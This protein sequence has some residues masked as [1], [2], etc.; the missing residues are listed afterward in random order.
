MSAPESYRRG[1]RP[2]PLLAA[3]AV[4]VANLFLHKPLSDMCDALFVRVGRGRYE[5]LSLV[6]IGVISAVAAVPGAL[7][8][9][10][11]LAKT[12]LPLSLFGLALLTMASQRWLLVSNIEL[13]H[14]PQFA[15]IAVL[16]LAAG[17]APK[18]AW[19][20]G[21]V[22]GL[23]DETYQHLVLYA[24]VP[25]TYFDVNDI[26]L[27]AIGAAWGV[28]LFGANRMAG[29]G[30]IVGRSRGYRPIVLSA[31][32][33]IALA[34]AFD[35]P[36]TKLMTRAATGRHYRVLST[37]EG[38]GAIAAVAALVELASIRRGGRR[39]RPPADS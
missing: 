24:G 8:L 1:P 25:N 14:F 5:L 3:A 34:I 22:A 12:W 29:E 37:G 13:V 39:P 17:V 2:L 35:P 33:M 19:L 11:A 30:P 31:G 18:V 9:R 15:L 36:A 26:V 10:P 7:R 23:L 20:C 4:S 21:S 27:N 38:L 32:A 6:G 16:F 28:C